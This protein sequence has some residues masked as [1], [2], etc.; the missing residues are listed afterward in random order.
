MV[1]EDPPRLNILGIALRPINLKIVV[2]SKTRS[3]VPNPVTR[4]IIV[5][6]KRLE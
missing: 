2:K 6:S 4:V 5:F 1:R 3:K